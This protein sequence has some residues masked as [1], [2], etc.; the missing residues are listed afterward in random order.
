MPKNGQTTTH[1]H[2]S[3]MIAKIMLKILQARIQQYMNGEL[4]DGQARFIK[5]RG[6]RDQIGNIHWIIKRASSVQFSSVTQS[7]LTLCDPMN[8]STPGLPVHHQLREFTQTRIHQV[9]QKNIY[10]CFIDY[11]K[12]FDSVDLNKVLKILKEMGIPEHLTC[13]LRNLYMQVRKATVRTEH[14]TTD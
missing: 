11:A 10:I 3:H 8:C 1:L 7:C 2:S 14:G 4:P 13:C 5:G 6:T 9:F 12:A